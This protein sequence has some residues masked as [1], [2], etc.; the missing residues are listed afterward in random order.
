MSTTIAAIL[1]RKGHEVV[2]IAPEQTV[3][4]VVAALR[5]RGIGALVVVDGDDGVAGIVSERDVVRHL[6]EVGGDVLLAR[7]ADV[8]T[9][10][11]HT[12]T[13]QS[14]MDELTEQM[15]E[16]RIRHLP[17]CEDGRLVGIV[18]I[19]DVVKER[20]EELH[21]HNRQLESYVAGSY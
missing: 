3:S 4:E 20:F 9:T 15:T 10:P 7:V 5:E 21:D 6:A 1:E 18:S 2:T 11:V 17:V 19:G 14:T 16:R 12:C 8:M 13:P